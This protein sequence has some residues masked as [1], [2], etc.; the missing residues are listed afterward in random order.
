MIFTCIK[1][2]AN[3]F[4]EKVFYLYFYHNSQ[5]T[6]VKIILFKRQKIGVPLKHDHCFFVFWE[7]GGKLFLWEGFIFELWN[8]HS[9]GT[10]FGASRVWCPSHIYPTG[11]I[12]YKYKNRRTNSKFFKKFEIWK[13]LFLICILKK[14]MWLLVLSGTTWKKNKKFEM[15]NFAKL[16]LKCQNHL[17][18]LRIEDWKMIV[19]WELKFNNRLLY[20]WVYSPFKIHNQSRKEKSQRILIYQNF[21]THS[22]FNMAKNICY[23]IIII[24]T[25]RSISIIPYTCVPAIISY[26]VIIR[27]SRMRFL[28]KKK[29]V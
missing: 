8:F 25:F 2:W 20:L 7:E 13:N 19:N 10:N 26:T 1:G 11:I 29:R 24:S 14:V 22:I 28:T 5:P 3:V 15:F 6:H 17:Q 16:W 9:G 18:I 27:T 4:S 12:S 21:S 23:V